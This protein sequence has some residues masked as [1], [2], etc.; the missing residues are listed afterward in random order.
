MCCSLAWYRSATA[1]L[2]Y[3]SSA[4][5]IIKDPSNKT[6][7][8]GLD[9]YDNS[10]NKVNVANEILQFHSKRLMQEVVGRLHADVSYTTHRGLRDV[11][12]YGET[13]FI[14]T[15]L[16]MPPPKASR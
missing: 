10:I 2:V 13:P 6:S 9:R 11:D 1:P 8:A 15:F 7:S 5:V 4:K 3:H 16:D 14:V 12:I